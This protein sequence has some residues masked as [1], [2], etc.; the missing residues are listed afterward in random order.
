M[1][2]LKMGSRMVRTGMMWKV[3]KAL[4]LLYFPPCL[5][6]FSE[7]TLGGKEQI[8]FKEL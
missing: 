1:R 8:N 2:L 3:C 7:H 5:F 4:D 6:N